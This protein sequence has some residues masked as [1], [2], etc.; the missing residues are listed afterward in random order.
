MG[1]WLFQLTELLRQTQLVEFSLWVS[2]WPFALWL[3]SNFLAIPGFQTIHILAIAVLFSATLMLNMRVW[4][5]AGKD[6]SL[7]AAYRRYRP[8]TWYAIAALALTGIILLISE[9]VRNMVNP[10]FWMKMIALAVAITVSL[11]FQRAVKARMGEW[12][13][14][15]AG[16][17]RL[18]GG[19][20]AL[21]LL[22]CAVITGG[23]WIAYAPV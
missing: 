15:P 18:R 10:I 12:E 6:Q 13:V 14:S 16:H 19:A 20:V 23:R 3:Q 21:T 2:D 8:W 11:V 1:E 7:E 22:W 5:L 9:P 17:A 4:G